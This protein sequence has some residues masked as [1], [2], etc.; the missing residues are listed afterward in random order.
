MPFAR[1]GSSGRCRPAAATKPTWNKQPAEL[2]ALSADSA[3]PD[4]PAAGLTWVATQAPF[5]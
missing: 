5:G 4:C 1:R 2:S 3:N